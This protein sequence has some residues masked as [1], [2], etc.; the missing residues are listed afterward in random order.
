MDRRL[1]FIDGIPGSGKTTTALWL[2]EQLRQSG[3][4]AVAHVEMDDPHPLHTFWTWGDGYRED[5]I[6]TEAFSAA[7]FTER[8]NAKA[9]KL[10]KRIASN[11]EVSI[12]EAYPF[13][14]PVRNHLKMGASMPE[15]E[16]F[17][18]EFQSAVAPSN[19]LLIFID[20]PNMRG[21]FEAAIRQRG[22]AFEHLLIH[23]ITRS[24]YGRRHRLSGF[25]GTL[26]FYETCRHKNKKTPPR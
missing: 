22:P 26:A 2:A 16:Q 14:L 5:D 1:I 18:T 17:F 6:V 25:E 12:I 23:S 15:I 10:V 11:S 7:K 20:R 21:T 13:Q 9:A 3:H 8:L 4:A 24:P 19:P